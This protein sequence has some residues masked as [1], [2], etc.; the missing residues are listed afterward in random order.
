MTAIKGQTNLSFL[1]LWNLPI[2]WQRIMSIGIGHAM[3]LM[4]NNWCCVFMR[5]TY[6]IQDGNE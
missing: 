3:S 2:W 1:L 5:M 6:Q 4:E